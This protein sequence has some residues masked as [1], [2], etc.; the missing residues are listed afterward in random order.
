MERIIQ[1]KLIDWKDSS[2]RKP[3]IIKGARQVGKTWLAEQLG[4]DHFR[5]FVKADL[6]KQP[7]LHRLFKGNIVPEKIIEEFEFYT[8]TRII[9]GETL[10]FIDEIQA[11]PRAVTALRYFF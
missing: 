10:I 5:T 6:E 8:G 3:L 2:R 9:P 1:G 7:D 4:R 11:C